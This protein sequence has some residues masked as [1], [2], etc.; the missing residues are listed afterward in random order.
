MLLP[1]CHFV[2]AATHVRGYIRRNEMKTS[3]RHQMEIFSALLT[4]CAGNSPVTGEFPTQRPVTRS[5]DVFFDL[6]PN[7]RLSKQSWGWWF[8]TCPLWR[9][10]NEA[11]V[12]GLI[13]RSIIC[14]VCKIFWVMHFMNAIHQLVNRRFLRYTLSYKRC[15]QLLA[16]WFEMCWKYTQL[17]TAKCLLKLRIIFLIGNSACQNILTTESRIYPPIIQHGWTVRFLDACLILILLDFTESIVPAV[18]CRCMFDLNLLDF[19]ESIFTAVPA[20]PAAMHLHE[21]HN[22]YISLFCHAV[23]FTNCKWKTPVQDLLKQNPTI[24]N[25]LHRSC[26]LSAVMGMPI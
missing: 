18:G 7:K 9:H 14:D 8:E 16:L 10:R 15:R 26:M 5:F 20:V 6:R 24:Q 11:R 1:L 21:F 12:C 23:N 2:T 13:K 3:W 4:I 22:I 19:A 25:T 17:I